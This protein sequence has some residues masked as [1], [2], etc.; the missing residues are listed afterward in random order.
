[1]M[2]DTNESAQ[3]KHS[4]TKRELSCLG[5]ITAPHG[6]RGAV[7]IRSFTQDP[8]SIFNYPELFDKK[9]KI[10]K[11]KYFATK[12]NNVFVVTL[13]GIKTCNEA[14]ALRSTKLYIYR[15]QLPET[16]E[17]EFY[18]EDLIGLVVMTTDNEEIGTVNSI[19]NHGAGDIL[20]IRTSTNAFLTLPFLKESV[21]TV[22]VKDG[23]IIINKDYLMG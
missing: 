3:K 5:E 20:E 17:D 18:Y 19:I 15:D 6:V 21:P 12:Q 2:T 23:K 16:N 13:D 4:S 14:E 11:L 8:A 1:M 10:Y 9:G 7:R 22:N